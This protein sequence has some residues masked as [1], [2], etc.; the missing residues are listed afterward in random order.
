MLTAIDR[1][2]RDELPKILINIAAAQIDAQAGRIESDSCLA[3]RRR[4]PAWPPRRQTAS[5]AG[6]A[7]PAGGSSPASA[8][9]QLRTSAAIRVGK[10]VVSNSVVRP[11]PDSPRSN[12]CQSC[13]RAAPQER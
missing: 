10:F 7:S 3:R 4:T 1:S 8:M 12:R 2:I 13:S 6:A 11:M 9:D 5:A